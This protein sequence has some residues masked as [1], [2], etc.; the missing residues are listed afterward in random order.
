M[1]ANYTAVLSRLKSQLAAATPASPAT[2][3]ATAFVYPDEYTSIDL[4]SL[5]VA[6]VS[7]RINN[8]NVMAKQARGVLH[9][10]WEAEVLLLVSEGEVFEDEAAYTAERGTLPWVDAMTDLLLGDYTLGGA[11]VY[12]GDGPT[13][14]RLFSYQIGMIGWHR[15]TFFGVVFMVPVAQ[16]VIF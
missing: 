6:I 16:K 4:D 12:V 2:A 1:S 3:V 5:P 10:Q 11:A 14:A 8:E 9:H 13:G 7:A 15:R